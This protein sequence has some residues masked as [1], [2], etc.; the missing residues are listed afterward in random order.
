[1]VS[2]K[3]QFWLYQYPPMVGR[4]AWQSKILPSRGV[5]RVRI[6]GQYVSHYEGLAR[7]LDQGGLVRGIRHS[8][9]NLI[10][11]QKIHEM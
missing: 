7:C 3:L 11:D 5:N 1:M 9:R 4:S 2:Q 6:S 10:D 8:L